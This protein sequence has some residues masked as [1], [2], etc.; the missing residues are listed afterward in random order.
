MYIV[1]KKTK[2]K[3][4]RW[5]RRVIGIILIV[6]VGALIFWFF[7]RSNFQTSG[8]A[9]S[10][11]NVSFDS[12]PKVHISEP[13]YSFD[14]PGDW[15]EL[16]RKTAP[17]NVVTWK[18]TARE[19]DAR[20]IDVYTD[21]IPQKVPLNRIVPV[22]GQD[23]RLGVGSSSDNCTQFTG[24]AASLTPYEATKARATLTNWQGVEF[25]CD[26]PNSLRNV[27]GASSPEA[28][29]KVSLTGVKGGKHSYFFVYTD[30]TAH[31]GQKTFTDM[32]ISFRAL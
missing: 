24:N 8:P 29:N 27:T 32:L 21:K 9:S 4:R 18:G 19:A 26:I 2:I 23:D 31:P 22:T 12:G 6:G 3:K 11:R 7:T 16:S 30:H 13:F 1:N 15:K 14:L 28:L 25:L 10:L 17:Y 20:T 5:P